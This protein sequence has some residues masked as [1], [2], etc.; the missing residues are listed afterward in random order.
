MECKFDKSLL[1]ALVDNAIEPIELI[2]LSEHL[3]VCS[4]CQNELKELYSLDKTL[5]IFFKKSI[6][7][8]DRLSTVTE[9]TIDN[10]FMEVEYEKK[11]KDFIYDTARMN[12]IIFETS[13]RFLEYIPGIPFI[14]KKMRT[15]YKNARLNFFSLTRKKAK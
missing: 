5:K 14:K 1:Q 7:Y 9:L 10:I 6:G 4:S 15:K 13:S 3:K 12:R 2:F 11:L 8:E